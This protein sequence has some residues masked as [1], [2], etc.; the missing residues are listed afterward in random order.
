MLNSR[1]DAR[2]E[3]ERLKRQEESDPIATLLY[4]A[5]AFAL[6]GMT[7]FGQSSPLLV[8]ALVALA[9]LFMAISARLSR[10]VYRRSH[11]IQFQV[12]WVC[13]VVMVV[14]SLIFMA[15][16]TAVIVIA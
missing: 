4:G 5:F 7:L 15:A 3:R 16:L 13:A 11:Q 2:A 9:T 12:W 14:A 8:L 1:A 6:A 10:R